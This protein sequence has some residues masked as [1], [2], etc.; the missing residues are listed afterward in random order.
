[1]ANTDPMIVIEQKDEKKRRGALVIALAVAF[2]AILAIGGTFAYLTY[3]ANQT[4]NRF[5]TG[6][7]TADVL[8]P[9]WTNKALSDNTATDDSTIEVKYKAG[10]GVAIPE[11]AYAMIPG[12]ETAKNPFVVNTSK[13]S[14]AQGFGALKVQFQ[15]WDKSADGDDGATWVAMSKEEVA[16]LLACYYIGADA[17]SNTSTAGFTSLGDEWVQYTATEQADFGATTAGE[18]DANGQMYFVNKTRL[19]SMAN[20]TNGESPDESTDATKTSTTWGFTADNTKS[21]TSPL[22]GYVRYI[23]GAD[24]TVI[25]AL[26][27]VLDPSSVTVADGKT[28]NP[29]WRMVIS[30]ACM[31]TTDAADN[32]TTA[33]S[34]WATS[35]KN[36]LD[37]NS[38]TV[39]GTDNEKPQKASGVREGSTLGAYID[40]SG[41]K[42]DGVG[43]P[44]PS[45]IAKNG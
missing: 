45:N 33:G 3:T 41:A 17:G 24:S 5:T 11:N 25:N 30:G 14:S 10:D 13:T 31:Q 12:S 36:L 26:K 4:P 8:E 29:G 39:N 22:F 32:P 18:S 16:K 35:F 19:W 2:V 6:E 20:K 21:S 38:S 28:W 27:E 42:V 7:L 15:K 1:M 43:I 44:E 9:A 23:D 34:I 40:D 37:I